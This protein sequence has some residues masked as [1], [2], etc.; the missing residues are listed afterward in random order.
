MKRESCQTL[1]ELLVDRALQIPALPAIEGLGRPPLTYQ[2]LCE[3]VLHIA[4]QLNDGGIR[5]NDRVALV[6]PNGPE[7]ATAFL[8]VAACATSAPLNPAYGHDEFEFYLSDLHVKALV[9]QQGV[10]S[11]AREVASAHGI[12][13]IQLRPIE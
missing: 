10:D 3:H 9:V 13:I 7:M 6:L 4:S 5:R 2:R 12:P 8:S 1:H 11:P